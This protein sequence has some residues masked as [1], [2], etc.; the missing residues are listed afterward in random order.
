MDTGHPVCGGRRKPSSG[1]GV[2]GHGSGPAAD[3]RAARLALID[4]GKSRSRSWMVAVTAGTQKS[5]L[6]ASRRTGSSAE[7]AFIFD[8][9][10]RCG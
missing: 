1:D 10:T 3:D 8:P 5:R 2:G 6:W 4:L 7:D 9:D